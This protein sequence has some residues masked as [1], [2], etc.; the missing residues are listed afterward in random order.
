MKLKNTILTSFL[1]FL[2]LSSWY[3]LRA[4]RNEMAVEN[5]GQDFLLILLSI[6]AITMLLVNPIYSWIASRT[7]YKKIII[8]CYSFLILNL[9]IFIFYSRSLEESDISQAIWLGRIF[10]VWCNIYSFFV[11]SIFW[12]LVINIFRDDKS[13]KL[14]GFIM[15][16]GSLGAIF[17]SEVSVRLSESFT[18]YGL[19]LFA[20][21]SSLLLFLAILVALYIVQSNNSEVLIKKV[22]GNWSDA[23]ANIISKREVR[24]VALYSWLFTGLMT[25]QWI[26]AIPIIESYSDLSADRIELFARIEQLVSPLT[27]VTQLFFTYLVISFFGI[28]SILIIYGFLFV[29]VFL[30]YGFFPSVGIVVF[31]QALLRVFE[32]GFNKPSREIMY[33]QLKKH[34]RYKSTVFIDTFITR[35]GDLTGSLFMF[36]GKFAAISVSIMP[37]LAI[38]FAGLFSV[39]GYKI[40][41]NFEEDSKN[42]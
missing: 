23:L 40:S 34:D 35:F 12:V 24:S 4:V 1:F 41:K 14:Y 22:G 11:V 39:T 6:T 21:S 10:Y 18:N 36:I 33:S 42:P 25:V 37:L 38:P 13:R 19:E 15:A 27:L 16:G 7:N 5:Y 31:A 2:V 3:V 26:S 17:G 30:L 9:F 8:Y 20:F 32:Y 28:S 29:I